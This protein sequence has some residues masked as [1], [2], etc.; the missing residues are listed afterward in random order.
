M[1]VKEYKKEEPSVTSSVLNLFRKNK[2]TT[3]IQ[4]H[5]TH[6]DMEPQSV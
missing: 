1:I 4:S 6:T 5:E 3:P 2:G